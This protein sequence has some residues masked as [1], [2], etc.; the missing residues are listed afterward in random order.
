MKTV[1][2]LSQFPASRDHS[3][4]YVHKGRYRHVLVSTSLSIVDRAALLLGFE[5]ASLH[6]STLTLLDVVPRPQRESTVHGLDAIALLH[7]AADELWWGSDS[8]MPSEA[9]SP[10][11]GKVVEGIIPQELL[12]A[13]SWRSECRCGDVAEAIVS[14][15]NESAAD[16][17]ILSAKQ[18]R[19]WLPLMP[20]AVRTIERRARANVIVIRSQAQPCLS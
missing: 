12:K 6:Q 18:F 3:Q 1:N 2:M 11:L 5:L 19:S 7:A 15:V 10:R 9:A 13:V 20:C 14:Y 16:L 4:P 8:R 17:V